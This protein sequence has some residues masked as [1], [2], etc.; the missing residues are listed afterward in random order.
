LGGLYTVCLELDRHG[1]STE[2]I[3]DVTDSLATLTDRPNLSAI[4][5]LLASSGPRGDTTMSALQAAI[6]AVT[7]ASGIGD[8]ASALLTRVGLDPSALP[9]GGFPDVVN[10]N[11]GNS[12]PVARHVAGAVRNTPDDCAGNGDAAAAAA[13]FATRIVDTVAAATTLKRKL[14][15][16]LGKRARAVRAA[17][18]SA[19][20]VGTTTPK[21]QKRLAL[22][23]TRTGALARLVT[24]ATG[25][26]LLPEPTGSALTALVRELT[27]RL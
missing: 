4:N 25:K 23:R 26:G 22:A 10:P 2:R 20:R 11:T 16:A 21:G 17:L 5:T 14:R 24:K 7:N 13:C 3:F 8:A 19:V 12:D 15:V 27:D 18:D 9:P 1:P 6:W